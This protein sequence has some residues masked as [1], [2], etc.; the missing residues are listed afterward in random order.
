MKLLLPISVLF[1]V[2][3]FCTGKMTQF[4]SGKKSTPTPEA[5]SNNKASPTPETKKDEG[6]AE[7]KAT[8]EKLDDDE[9]STRL[10]ELV[11][12]WKNA[13]AKGDSATLKRLLADDFTIVDEEGKKYNKA[14][15]I[16]EVSGGDSSFKS[17]TVSEAKIESSTDDTATMSF[18]ASYNF[19]KEKTKTRETDKFVQRDGEWQVVYS[20]ATFIN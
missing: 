14:Q 8:P 7:S 1:V 5:A 12:D 17:F 16:K 15:W 4:L 11:T 18:V 19:K 20:Q 3:S 9:L 13:E 6:K 10:S 2:L